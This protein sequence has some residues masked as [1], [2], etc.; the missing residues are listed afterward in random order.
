MK[1]LMSLLCISASI[2]FPLK[3]HLFEFSN[4][5]NEEC[6]IRIHLIADVSGKWYEATI[7]SKKDGHD[8]AMHTFKFGADQGYRWVEAEWHKGGFCL[9]DIQI[10][11]PLMEKKQTV[12]DDGNTKTVYERRYTLGNDGK[13]MLDKPMWNPWRNLEV[14]H[15]K[16]ESY[17]EMLNAGAMLADGLIEAAA[18]VATAATGVPVPAFKVGNIVKAAGSLHAYGTCKNVHYDLIPT[19]DFVDPRLERTMFNIVAITIAK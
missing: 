1:R 7:K 16:S 8:K 17:V 18:D 14:L 3:A 15:L 6:R 11:T 4:H 12:D 10:S 13:P 19:A 9:G 5:T 2:A